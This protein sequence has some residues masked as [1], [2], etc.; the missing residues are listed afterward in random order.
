MILTAHQPTYLP[1]LGLFHKIAISDLYISYSQVQYQ[2][3]NWNHRNRIKTPQGPQWLTLSVF[4]RNH[5]NISLNDMILLYEKPW[6][7]KHWRTINQ[8]YRKAPYFKRYV[9]FF[10]DVY[11]RE[12][13]NLVELNEY[14]LRWFVTTL[15]IKTPLKADREYQFSGSKSDRAIDMCCKTEAKVF[16][17]GELGKKYA[18]TNDFNTIGCIPYF[19]SYIHPTYPQLYGVF[20]PNMSIIDLLFNCGENSLEILLSNNVTK[21]D[22]QNLIK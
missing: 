2:T 8:N 17:F 21:T 16:V 4:R 14:M 1:W 13:G 10:E 5:M 7:Q 18:H 9:D 22:I 20:E 12:W 15:G 6:R 3:D 11:Q 19:Q